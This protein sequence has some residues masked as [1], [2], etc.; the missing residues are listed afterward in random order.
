[1]SFLYP[2]HLLNVFYI[3]VKYHENIL[4]G[5][6]VMVR[7][8]FYNFGRLWEITPEPSRVAILARNTPTQC[9]LQP[10]KVS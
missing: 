3:L 6:R 8:K 10:D 2:T 4:K 7:T 1:M 5:F 9:P